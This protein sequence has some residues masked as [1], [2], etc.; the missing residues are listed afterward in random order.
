[1]KK[2]LEQ[3]KQ[4]GL[5]DQET[6]DRILAHEKENS[7]PLFL[8]AVSGLAALSILISLVALVAAIGMGFRMG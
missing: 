3:W 6:V 1:M 8:Y 2:K 5:I 7:R 4:N